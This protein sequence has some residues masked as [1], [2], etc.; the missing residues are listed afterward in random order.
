MTDITDLE[1][2]AI[3]APVGNS[4]HLS[5]FISMAQAGPN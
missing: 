5:D 2:V 1:L 3:V 4:D